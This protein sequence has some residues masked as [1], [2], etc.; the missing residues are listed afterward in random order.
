[1]SFRKD[2]RDAVAAADFATLEPLIAGDRKTVRHLVGLS[3][4]AEPGVAGNAARALAIAARHHPELVAATVRR[5]VWAMNDESGTNALSAPAV[6]E[7]IA[8]ETPDLLVPVVPDLL[9]LSGDPGLRPGLRRALRTI[10]RACPGQVSAALEKDLNQPEE[11]LQ[12]E[13]DRMARKT[14]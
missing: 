7:A 4:S 3:Y 2:I 8:E 6:I 11:R 1:M 14:R 10:A 9:R 13:L 5:L 12:E